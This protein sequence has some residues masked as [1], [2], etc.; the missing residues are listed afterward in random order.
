MNPYKVL[1]INTRAG[2]KEIIQAAAAALRKREFSGHVI[3]SAQ[4]QLLDPTAQPIINFLYSFNFKPL[5]E[6]VAASE[7]SHKMAVNL[8]RLTL[9]DKDHEQ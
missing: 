5:K 8:K 3:A 2:K 6:T 9:F 1:E 4:K 7:V